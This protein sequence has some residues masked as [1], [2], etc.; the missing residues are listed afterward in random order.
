MHNPLLYCGVLIMPAIV[1]FRE[2]HITMDKHKLILLNENKEPIKDF[3]IYKSPTSIIVWML[4]AWLIGH[5]YTDFS[6]EE[7]TDIIISLKEYEAPAKAVPEGSRI[8]QIA[9]GVNLIDEAV[10]KTIESQPQIAIEEDKEEVSPPSPISWI[11]KISLISFVGYSFIDNL[12]VSLEKYNLSMSQEILQSRRIGRRLYVRFPEGFGLSLNF[13][14]PMYNEFLKLALFLTD[15]LIFIIKDERDLKFIKLLVYDEAVKKAQKIFILFG[16]AIEPYLKTIQRFSMHYTK[17]WDEKELIADLTE[18]FITYGYA[19]YNLMRKKSFIS[20]AR[21]A[22]E[23]EIIS[24]PAIKTSFFADFLSKIRAF[25]SK[26]F[27]F[28]K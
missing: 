8:Q 23:Q 11:K 27:F 5:G 19:N 1:K 9:F 18:T 15:L 17:V 12:I 6:V 10:K 2:F 13:L 20:L 3:D 16:T 24:A 26:I 7:L 25:F 14:F 21:T 28:K 4:K 22:K